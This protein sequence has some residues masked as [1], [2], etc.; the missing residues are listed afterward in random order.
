[1]VGL[2]I[3]LLEIAP[4]SLLGPGNDLPSNINAFTWQKFF[5]S[6]QCVEIVISVPTVNQIDM[7]FNG[8]YAWF[9]FRLFVSRKRRDN[10][11]VGPAVLSQVL[12]T[13]TVIDNHGNVES[14]RG[15]TVTKDQVP[16]VMAELLDIRTITAKS[17]AKCS[18]SVIVDAIY[19]RSLQKFACT[20]VTGCYLRIREPTG[21]TDN[22][23]TRTAN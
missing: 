21:K 14:V 23:K 9:S 13:T 8:F 4:P 3:L 19:D 5:D 20:N 16:I 7:S 11:A 1:V 15:G 12:D 10:E 17:K 22:T 18:K 6:K 2:F